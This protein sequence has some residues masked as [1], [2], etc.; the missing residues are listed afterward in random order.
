MKLSANTG[1]LWKEH[2]FLERIRLAA[3]HHFDAVEFHDEAQ[4]EDLAALKDVLAETGLPVLGLNVRM[5][6]SFGI[7]VL[8]GAADQC[9]RDIDAAL[10]LADAID[11]PAIHLLSGKDDQMPGA[12]KNYVAALDHA[13]TA[14]DRTVLIE[15]ITPNGVPGYWMN[16]LD[17]AQSVLEEVDHPRLKILFDYFHI[18]D[19]H[20]DALSRF[21]QTQDHIGHIQI[22][23]H[24][25]RSEPDTACIAFM[26][27]LVDAGYQGF[28]GCEYKPVDGVENGLAWRQ[29]T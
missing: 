24:P 8:D 27:A 29:H 28:F 22:A 10:A 25:G 18:T 14:G 2:T 5:G 4:R 7:A 6:D 26:K 17:L 20:G 23:A 15:P 1:F 19:I 21:Q 11:C 16:D 9:K 13:L 3:R 12:R